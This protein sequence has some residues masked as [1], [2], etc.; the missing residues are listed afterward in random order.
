MQVAQER[1]NPESAF[2]SL[3]ISLYDVNRQPLQLNKGRF[4]VRVC[5]ALGHSALA[6]PWM[7]RHPLREM[8]YRLRHK[9]LPNVQ[10]R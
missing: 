6:T 3:D 5:L 7:L 1:L 9:V 2:L 10:L 4:E 8:P